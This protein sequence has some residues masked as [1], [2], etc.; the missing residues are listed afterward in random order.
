M[1]PT[2]VPPSEAKDRG[3]GLLLQR[4]A[5]IMQGCAELAVVERA[6]N[7]QKVVPRG[8][9]Q[10]A[11]EGFAPGMRRDA[12]P[13]ASSPC[14]FVDDL[15]GAPPREAF[16]S[17]ARTEEREVR[18]YRCAGSPQRYQP[19]PDREP[20]TRMKRH[21]QPRMLPFEITPGDP[22]AVAEL[23]PVKNV[24]DPQGQKAPEPQPRV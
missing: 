8:F 6:G 5:Q 12:E 17:L 24:A 10:T 20:R 23:L 14:R 13:Q 1:N 7:D 9:V 4:P 22:H 11:G 19:A 21:R 15:L 18:G 3:V 2:A 16:S